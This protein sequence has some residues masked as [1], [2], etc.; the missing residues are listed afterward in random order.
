MSP[1]Q[2]LAAL[3]SAQLSAEVHKVEEALVQALFLRNI[4]ANQKDSLVKLRGLAQ[5]QLAFEQLLERLEEFGKLV[6]TNHRDL[7]ETIVPSLMDELGVPSIALSE[8]Q[9]LSVRTKI[10]ASLPA[11][12]ANE[13]AMW[14][15]EHGFG[16]I[17]KHEVIASFG[18]REGEIADKVV[19]ALKEL[20]VKPEVKKSVNHMTLGA[21][22]RERLAEGDEFPMELFGVFRRRS[23]IIKEKSS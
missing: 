22:A 2:I 23:S 5:A 19:A 1:D 4:A 6:T 10:T 7:T 18:T 14:L 11:S 17:V 9:E 12:R 15:E 21:W 20:D 13:G 16:S 3:N 8:T